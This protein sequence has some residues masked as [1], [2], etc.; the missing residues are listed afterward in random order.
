MFSG[1][2]P[3][4]GVDLIVKSEFYRLIITPKG[5]AV[6]DPLEELPTTVT[7]VLPSSSLGS[8][9]TLKRLKGG[10]YCCR[11]SACLVCPLPQRA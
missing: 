6:P 3:S 5:M 1:P 7:N 4:L 8:F 10:K 2:A 9:Q 11:V